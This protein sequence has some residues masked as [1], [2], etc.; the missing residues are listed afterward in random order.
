MNSEQK[1]TTESQRTQRL[2]RE[3]SE[4]VLLCKAGLTCFGV[5]GF[6][7]SDFGGWEKRMKP[8]VLI[9]LFLFTYA[10][11]AQ[12]SLQFNSPVQI[13][14]GQR[15]AAE[16][17][18]GPLH[19]GVLNSKLLNELEVTYPQKAKD[20]NIQGRVEVQLLTNEDGEVIFANPL[21]GPEELWAESVRAVVGARIPPVSVAGEPM[22]I[23]GRIII[24][25]KNG[26]AVV[27]KRI[28][29]E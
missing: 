4:Q 22:K 18:R 27:P 11:A 9:M 14:Y 20:K 13:L 10:G 15:T 12:I 28:E 7:V 29:F 3:L 24:D 21:S 2:H 8:L 26:Q 6:N 19:S 16:R 1:L 23:A 25:F 5:R 17:R